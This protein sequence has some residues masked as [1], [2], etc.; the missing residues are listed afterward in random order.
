M[1]DSAVTVGVVVGVEHVLDRS[2]LRTTATAEIV[3]A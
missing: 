3:A 2:G 1:P